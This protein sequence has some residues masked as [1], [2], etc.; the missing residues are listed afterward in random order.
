MTIINLLLIVPRLLLLI[1]R[2]LLWL[3]LALLGII[4]SNNKIID[5]A[6]WISPQESQID[7]DKKNLAISRIVSN[8]KA[9]QRSIIKNY[10][11]LDDDFPDFYALTILAGLCIVSEEEYYGQEPSLL[12]LEVIEQLLPDKDRDFCVHYLNNNLLNGIETYAQRWLPLLKENPAGSD[13]EAMQ[14]HIYALHTIYKHIS[15]R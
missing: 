6:E 1:I 5:L 12:I 13:E 7:N 8:S 10:G 14:N 2:F 3:P 9:T 4:T 15:R 11:E